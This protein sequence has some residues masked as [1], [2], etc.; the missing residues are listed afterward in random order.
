MGDTPLVLGPRL[1]GNDGSYFATGS[2]TIDPAHT[3]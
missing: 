1:R 2:V 3:R